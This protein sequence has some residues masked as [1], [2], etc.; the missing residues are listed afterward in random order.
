MS[1]QCRRMPARLAIAYFLRPPVAGARLEI[2]LPGEDFVR[3]VLRGENLAAAV[4]DALGLD[5]E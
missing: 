2:H 5:M 3:I 1:L 4:N